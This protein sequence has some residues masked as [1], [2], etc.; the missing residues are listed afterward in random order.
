MDCGKSTTV[1]QLERSLKRVGISSVAGK[2]SG[3]GCFYETKN[4]NTNFT[5]DFT[6][7]WLPSTCGRDGEKV[8]RAADSVLATL[9]AQNSDVII[10][11]FGGELIGP[12][13]VIEILERVKHQIDFTIFVT[14]DLCGLKG[15]SAQLASMNC[16]IDLVTGP[17]VNT[18]LGVDLVRQWFD[19]AS[20]SNQDEMT[21]TAASIRDIL[22][23][24]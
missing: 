18:S 5:V 23:R 9:R 1:I 3:F 16:K 24:S 12:Y 13:R 22:P 7:F 11:E 8:L 15:G 2:I 6:D 20:E 4:L 10:L 14:F 17:L 21:T 19:I